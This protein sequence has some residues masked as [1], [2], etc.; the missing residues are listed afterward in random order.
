MKS[1]SEGIEQKWAFH[2]EHVE[3][4]R[5]W[6]AKFDGLLVDVDADLEENEVFLQIKNEIQKILDAKRASQQSIQCT[7]V[8]ETIVQVCFRSKHSKKKL[9]QLG[10]GSSGSS[11]AGDV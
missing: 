1:L 6:F 9:F 4:L 7:Q 8:A 10:N 5:S 3:A 2:R 11:N